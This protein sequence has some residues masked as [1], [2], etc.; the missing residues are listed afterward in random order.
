MLSKMGKVCSKTNK[1]WYSWLSFWKF[2]RKYWWWKCNNRLL[3]RDMQNIINRWKLLTLSFKSLQLGHFGYHPWNFSLSLFISSFKS[4]Y[5]LLHELMSPHRHRKTKNVIIY[6]TSNRS[7]LSPI[8]ASELTRHAM[9]LQCSS[10]I[11]TCYNIV[12]HGVTKSFECW[13]SHLAKFSKVS[14]TT[15]KNK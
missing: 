2:K 7:M 11:R 12:I 1:Y 8:L 10:K 6:C 13:S 15:R 5:L 14:T 3:T 4:W 9:R